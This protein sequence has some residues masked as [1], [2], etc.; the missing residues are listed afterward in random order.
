MVEELYLPFNEFENE[1]FKYR[2]FETGVNS[3]EL[4][5][6]Y[7]EKDRVVEVIKSNN[8][9]IQLDNQLPYKLKTGDIININKYEYHRVIK[10][11]D[12][13]IIRFKEL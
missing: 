3:E 11:T 13:L 7:D 2:V 5:W 12:N 8:W 1:G 4:K 6:H 10:G 9:Q